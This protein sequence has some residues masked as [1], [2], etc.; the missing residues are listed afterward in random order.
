MLRQLGSSLGGMQDF[1]YAGT[2]HGFP[3]L[4]SASNPIRAIGLDWD[5]TCYPFVLDLFYGVETISEAWSLGWRVLAR[6]IR[7]RKDGPRSSTH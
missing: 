3:D 7:G 6:C 2:T 1:Y 4:A 5:L